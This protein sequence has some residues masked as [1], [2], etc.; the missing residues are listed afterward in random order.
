MPTEAARKDSTLALD[1]ARA[2][3]VPLFA[4]Q[5]ADTRLRARAEGRPRAQG[6]RVDRDAL[7]G[8][9][10]GRT[11][12]TSSRAGSSARATTG[13]CA[14]IGSGT[15]VAF[16]LRRG[17]DV[18]W[19]H[20]REGAVA[21]HALDDGF[22]RRVDFGLTAPPAV[23]DRLWAAV[24][25]PRHQSLFAL[26]SKVPEFAV[27]G[28]PRGARPARPRRRPAAR[29]R[30]AGGGRGDRRRGRGRPASRPTSPPS[31]AAT[32]ASSCRPAPRSCYAE[33]AGE[34]RDLL[35]LH[36]AGSDGR[37]Y[38]HLLADPALRAD[39]RM[40]AFDLPSHG[41][42]TPPAGLQRGRVAADHR[43]LRRGDRRRRRRARPRAS[44]RPRLLD[45]RGDLPRARPAPSGPVRG[46]RRVP[47]RR[48]R[49]GPPGR[50]GQARAGQ[51][52]A[53]RARVGRRPDEPDRPARA[54]RRGPLGLRPE[55]PRRLL[56]R[57]RVLLAASGTRAT[58]WAVSTPP[59]ARST[60]WPASTT[61]RARRS[62]PA[63]R[64]SASP[65][66]GSRRCAG[67]GHFPMAEDPQ[68][69]LGYLRP[70]LADL[71]A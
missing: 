58:G 41:R 43:P 47:G 29:A 68:A 22:D 62:S 67:L 28:E 15:D 71:V 60:S 70:V 35:F 53:V 57:H 34:G 56:G 49:R 26:L 63:R 48:P 11:G 30:P 64:P 38:H 21:G 31:P 54:P 3:G 20:L 37:Q 14:A 16:T 4:M 65:A 10:R 24:P 19:I 39:W 13:A 2:G 66:R 18:V 50:V 61:T 9:R 32:S 40:T 17:D 59:A 33:Q 42:S 12:R 8:L 69:F 44:G 23:W 5:A 27:E 52:E 6:L 1:M 55:R 51:R 7:G 25:P 45:G 36:T 46:R